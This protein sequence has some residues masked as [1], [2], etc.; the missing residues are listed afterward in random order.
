MYRR[1]KPQLPNRTVASYALAH[2]IQKAECKLWLALHRTP[3]LGDPELLKILVAAALQGWT[4]KV[5]TASASK[6]NFV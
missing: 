6:A 2:G 1:A 5:A 4:S 3:K